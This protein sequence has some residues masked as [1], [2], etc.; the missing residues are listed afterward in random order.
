[1]SRYINLTYLF[2]FVVV[3]QSCYTLSNTSSLKFEIAV[4]G[5]VIIPHDYKTIAVR[6]NNANISANPVFS[7]YMEDNETFTDNTNLDSI[8]SKIYFQN[9][10][11][12]LKNHRYFDSVIVLEPMNYSGTKLSD[13]LVYAKSSPIEPADSGKQTTVNNN[14][15]RFAQLVKSLSKHDSVKTN[16]KLIDPEFGLYS[17]DDIQKIADSTNADLLLSFDFY[18]SRD[19]IFSRKFISDLT[20]KFIFSSFNINEATEIVHVLSGWTFYDLKKSEIIYTHINIDTI[21][22]NEPA[23]SLTKA[24]RV[25]PPRRDAVLHAAEIAGINFAGYVAPH[26]IEVE[27]MYYKSRQVELK[28]TDDLI[29]QNRW[30]EAAEIWKKNT[31]NKNKKIAAKSMFNMALACEMNDE[32]DAAI[33]WAV[34]SFHARRKD[35]YHTDA[36]KTYI[37]ILA[38]RK[39]DFKRMEIE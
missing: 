25:L 14:I 3:F 38:M 33:D 34:K 19:G 15:L 13:S 18:G 31:T 4:P 27:R 12:Q 28:K 29:E 39:I 6:F 9:F 21:T 10:A 1:M 5:K 30:L 32:L 2:V 36:C 8:A 23:F 11:A 16:T 22:W 17:H 26:W 35:V 7:D 20:E 37:K 24:K